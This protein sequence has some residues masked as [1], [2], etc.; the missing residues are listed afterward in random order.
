MPQALQPPGKTETGAPD[1]TNTTMRAGQMRAQVQNAP[2]PNTPPPFWALALL[3]LALVGV[4]A[5]LW[6]QWR[7]GAI[8]VW[9]KFA[10]SL[11]AEFQARDSFAPRFVSG[12][13]AERPFFLETAVSHEDDAPYY[14]TRGAMPIR[15]PAGLILGVR[16]KSM[17]EEAQ[18]RNERV[19]YGL[20]DADFERCF[21]VV[22]NDPDDL[23]TVLNPEVRRGLRR[24][25]DVEIYVRYDEIEWRRAGE[26]SD[27]KALQ[28]LST[29][30]SQL[31]ETIEALPKRTLTLTKR[32]QDEELIRKGV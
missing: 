10:A 11:G 12:V 15:N 23:P 9:R 28:H 18:T 32:L 26:V 1:G 27:L 2:N 14:H 16:R 7:R 30:L 22:T 29:L 20:E 4:A 24:Y 31:A 21:F 13:F 5:A 17:L 6:Y 19:D 25:G 3:T 8:R